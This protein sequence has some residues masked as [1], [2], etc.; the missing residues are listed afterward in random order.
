LPSFLAKF[1]V[2]NIQVSR[3]FVVTKGY[4]Q[5]KYLSLNLPKVVSLKEIGAKNLHRLKV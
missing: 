2:L 1:S 4:V 3:S 5:F